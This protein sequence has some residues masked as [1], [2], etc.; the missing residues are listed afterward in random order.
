MVRVGS[1]KVMNEDYNL[2]LKLG[3]TNPLRTEDVVSE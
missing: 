1:E 2:S 3:V